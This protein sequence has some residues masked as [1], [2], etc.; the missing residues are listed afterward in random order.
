MQPDG[1]TAVSDL[2][3]TQ[4]APEPGRRGQTQQWRLFRIR[5]GSLH[6][7]QLTTFQNR[8]SRIFNC[9][10]YSTR[11][12]PLQE[13]APD[14]SFFFHTEHQPQQ[15]TQRFR[16]FDHNDLH[17]APPLAQREKH[18]ADGHHGRQEHHQRL[19]RQAQRQQQTHPERGRPPAARAS[20]SPHGDPPL[21]LFGTVYAS[22]QRV[23]AALSYG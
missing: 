3:R 11:P 1:N 21:A 5:T 6:F 4:T 18:A 10:H 8:I 22:L 13:A 15:H 19:C 17:F 16:R 23:C 2:C 14:F 7:T 12:A 20:S 9:L